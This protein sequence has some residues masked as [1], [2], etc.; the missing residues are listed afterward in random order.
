L[1]KLAPE[2]TCA[3]DAQLEMAG[4]VFRC[5]DLLEYVGRR[6]IWFHGESA[7]RAVL[8]SGPEYDAGTRPCC[9]LRC[10]WL[11]GSGFRA[12]GAALHRA[13][14][15]LQREADAS[16]LLGPELG[17]GADDRYQAATYRHHPS[18]R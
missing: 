5:S 3:L 10:I 13:W 8:H 17:S 4:I 14:F 12:A 18:L 11:P 7:Y 6:R 9:A 16:G 2:G 1:R 15:R